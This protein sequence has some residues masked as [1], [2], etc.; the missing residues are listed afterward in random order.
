MPSAGIPLRPSFVRS[1]HVLAERLFLN[2]FSYLAISQWKVA[3]LRPKALAAICP[4]EG[5]TDV[6]SD[7][8]Y[9]GGVREDGF[10]P[11]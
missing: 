4:W 6:Y 7:L 11:L 9:P 1:I 10:V 5:F 2:F 8:A 3:A